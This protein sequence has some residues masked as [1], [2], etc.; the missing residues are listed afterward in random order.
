MKVTDFCEACTHDDIVEVEKVLDGLAV[1][2]KT[3]GKYAIVN[4]DSSDHFD[5]T[6][7]EFSATPSADPTYDV[8]AS[9][10]IDW[11]ATDD[12]DDDGWFDENEVNLDILERSLVIDVSLIRDAVRAGYPLEPAR[13][14]NYWLY[15]RIGETVDKMRATGNSSSL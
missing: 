15:N 3:D 12:V 13:S 8:N 6:P 7:I 5:G 2:E 10:E 14:F 11:E 9:P 1:Y 4:L